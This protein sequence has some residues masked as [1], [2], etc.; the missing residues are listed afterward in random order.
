MHTSN[1]NNNKKEKIEL[2][3]IAKY[4]I[5]TVGVRYRGFKFRFVVKNSKH[6]LYKLYLYLPICHSYYIF[7]RRYVCFC[8]AQVDLYLYVI[9][10][11]EES[12]LQQKQQ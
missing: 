1:N 6:K 11:F 5:K 3:V 12:L 2:I 4:Y 8:E 9:F 7:K 10:E